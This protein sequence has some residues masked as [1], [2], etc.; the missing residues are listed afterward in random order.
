MKQAITQDG[1]LRLHRTYL[2]KATE[3]CQLNLV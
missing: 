3:L 2:Q 1:F